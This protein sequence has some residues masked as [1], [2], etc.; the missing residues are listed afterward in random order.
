MSTLMCCQKFK[1]HLKF[2]CFKDCL[3]LIYWM[4]QKIFGCFEISSLI[5]EKITLIIQ[6]SGV[7]ILF[8]DENQFW[9]DWNIIKSLKFFL[10]LKLNIMNMFAPTHSFQ[11]IWFE[12][13]VLSHLSNLSLGTVVSYLKKLT[14]WPGTYLNL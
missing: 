5:I 6:L 1:A 4:S 3:Y 14:L 7:I 11:Y 13:C 10:F 8:E 2:C 9:K 12:F